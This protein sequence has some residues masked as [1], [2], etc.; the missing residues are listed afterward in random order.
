MTI[1]NAGT[2]ARKDF[3]WKLSSLPWECARVPSE[4]LRCSGQHQTNAHLVTNLK[5]PYTPFA[6][7]TDSDNDDLV[8]SAPR[9]NAEIINPFH[10]TSASASCRGLRCAGL[11]SS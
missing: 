9:A 5:L 1:G 4:T 10:A 2:P 8:K 11:A 6:L 3:R 7:P